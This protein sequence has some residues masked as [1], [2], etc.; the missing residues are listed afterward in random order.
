MALPRCIMFLV[1]LV[2]DLDEWGSRLVSANETDIPDLEGKVAGDDLDLCYLTATEAIQRFKARELSPVE[3]MQA[4][5]DRTER[6][7]SKINAIT[8][9]FYDRALQQAKDA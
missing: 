3:L 2:Y 5:I 1:A 6:A 8:Y 4:L 7:N 9:K